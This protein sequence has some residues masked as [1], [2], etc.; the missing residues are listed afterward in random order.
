MIHP[1]LTHYRTKQQRGRWL[2]VLI[3]VLGLAC[4]AMSV[5]GGQ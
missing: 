3:C 5:L 1:K 4:L 2:G